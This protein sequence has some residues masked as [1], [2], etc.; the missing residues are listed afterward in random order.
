[1]HVSLPLRLVEYTLTRRLAL[2]RSPLARYPASRSIPSTL[3]TNPFFN[4]LLISTLHFLGR[5]TFASKSREKIAFIKG[6]ASGLGGLSEGLQARRVLP[7]LLE[8]VRRSPIL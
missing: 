2:I 8:E 4:S 7:G 1:M 5:S 6:R 3:S